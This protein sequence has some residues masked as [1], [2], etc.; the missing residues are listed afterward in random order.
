MST[1]YLGIDVAKKDFCV[2][3]SQKLLRVL[4]NTNEGF[5]LLI[6]LLAKYEQ[7]HVILEAS[8]GYERALTDALHDAGITVSVV[9]PG[10][11]RHFAKSLKVLAKTD[12]I[13]ATVIARFGEATSPKPSEKTPLAKKTATESARIAPSPPRSNAALSS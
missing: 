3:T 7:P 8:G 4:A 6:E 9:Q 13:D 2:A 1:A 12:A 10:C 11:V 5:R